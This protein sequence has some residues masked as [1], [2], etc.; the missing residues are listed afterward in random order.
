LDVFARYGGIGVF[1]WITGLFKPPQR[2]PRD[3]NAVDAWLYDDEV[4]K[5][6]LDEISIFWENRVPGPPIKKLS[7]KYQNDQ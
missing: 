4:L 3:R 1:K 5:E 2:I 7:K 6:R